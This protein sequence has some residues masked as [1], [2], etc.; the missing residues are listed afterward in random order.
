MKNILLIASFLL[1]GGTL[2]AQTGTIRGFVYEEETGEPVIFT[3]VFLKGT[4]YGASTDVNGYFSI[5]KIPAGNYTLQSSTL[6]YDT[7]SVNITLKKG[8]I[9]TEKLILKKKAVDLK[10]VEISAE[11]QEAK[12]EVK[13][14]VQKVTPKDIQ[15]IPTIGGEADLAQY[16]Q[17]L[18]GVVFTGDQGGQ[19]YIRG[20]SPIQNKVLLDGMII[21]NPFHSIGLFSVFETDIMRNADIYT[22]G[23]NAENGGRISSVMDITTRDGNVKH[24]SGKVAASTFAAKAI[25]EGPLKKQ[26]KP[27]GASS[28]YLIT[29]KT[30]YLDKTTD[31]IYSHV[32]HPEG[33]PY[34]FTDLYGKLSFNGSNGSKFSAFG[35]N[36]TDNVNYTTSKLNWDAIGGGANFI[37]VPDASPILIQGDFSY[38][39]YLIEQTEGER[40]RSSG[41]NGFNL[42]L[43]FTYFVLDNEIKYG[44]EVI[45][46]STDFQY[47]N[48]L[49]REISQNE[50]TTEMA[51]YFKYKWNRGNWV[52]EPSFR[53]HYYAAL[54]ELSLEPRLGMKYNVS[55]NFRLKSAG[56]LYSQNLISSQSD[57]DVVNLFNGFLSG[58]DNLQNDFT[59][60]DGTTAEVESRLQKAWHAIL[61][62]ELDITNQISW[63]VEGYYKYFPQLT[64]LN[65]YK[66]YE[67]PRPDQPDI[68]WRDF[69]V[70]DG[71][72]YGVDM[73]LSY[74][75]KQL[76]LWAVYSVSYV[77]RWDG[78]VVYNPVFDRRHNVNFVSTYKFGDGLKWEVSARWNFGSGFPFTQTLGYY[79]KFDFTDGVNSDYVS[80]NGELGIQYADIN[81]GRLPSYHRMDFNLKRTM[82]LTANSVL[83]LNAGVTNVYNRENIFYY[84][85]IRGERVDQLPI[86]PSIG[87]SLTF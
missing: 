70:E 85:R 37:V 1:F 28:S 34:T 60:R 49:G 14:S 31:A 16:L 48:T 52:I 86:M 64:T 79:E 2:L 4:T 77:D 42:G 5:S 3:N 23:F 47:T 69:I 68:L 58:P 27:G 76:Y 19:L 10:A 55:D 84:D 87:A 24:F 9:I 35:F 15:S 62:F 75:A 36:F 82:A 20:G 61:G 29:A 46:F 53:A 22:G 13:M 50:N 57:R 80:G 72:A 7:A 11:K 21:Y 66:I 32:P 71:E 67:E 81:Q 39:R 17:V 38:S 12:T 40:F 78:V 56:G 65:R 25:L 74:K 51:G 83:E 43:D 6:G 73:T 44:I 59:Q 54:S 33:L 63:N 8:Q 41:I 45:G 26:T 18:P 30:S